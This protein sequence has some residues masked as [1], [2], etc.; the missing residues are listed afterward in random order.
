MLHL[1]THL[2]N[3]GTAGGCDQD[4]QRLLTISQQG[5]SDR[6]GVGLFNFGDVADAQLILVMSLD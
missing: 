6:R 2:D 5:V 3:V 4:A 1:G